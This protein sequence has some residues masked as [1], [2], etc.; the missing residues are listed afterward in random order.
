MKLRDLVPLLGPAL[1]ATTLACRPSLAPLAPKPAVPPVSL[2]TAA[3]R[4]SVEITY[5]GS[6]GFVIR[7][8]EDAVVT[9]PSFTHH[10]LMKTFLPFFSIS[11]DTGLVQRMLTGV[12]LDG[13]SSM[14]VGHAHYDHLLDAPV[15]ATMLPTTSRIYGGPTTKNLLW[16]V[17]DLQSR[18]VSIE[19]AAVG[20]KL[21]RGD[22]YPSA[23]SSI[24]FMALKS[25]HPPNFYFLWFFP[26]TYA[27]GA[28]TQPRS[29]LPR[30]PRGWKMGET[31]A[32]LIDI[33]GADGKPVFRIFYQDAASEPVYASLPPVLGNDERPVDV[34]I[35]CAGNYGYATD[36][37][38]ALLKE[39]RPRH[40]IVGH[41]E[42]FF[43]PPI[44]SF[45]A[46]RFT[47]TYR[48][49]ARIQE[50]QQDAWVTPEPRARIVY[51]F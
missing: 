41:W 23:T 43:R 22:W 32:Y 6:G 40:V 18:L 49:A 21:H 31:Y 2:C 1:A 11:P 29:S 15:V 35:I 39:L 33:M 44:P 16:A 20:D 25:N 46:I 8:G 38:S 30:T 45:Q 42:D 7:H 48:L 10:G 47:D 17:P 9:A 50:T 3:C 27:G 12:R 36:Y 19:G 26:Y 24:R 4:D 13:V 37:P 34:A 14:L 5:L 51:R 28:V